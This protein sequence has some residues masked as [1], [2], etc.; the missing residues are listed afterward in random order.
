MLE[1]HGGR[2]AD[3]GGVEG[4][5]LLG[6]ECQQELAAAVFLGRGHRAVNLQG[7]RAWALGVAEDVQLG[8]IEA[9]EEVVRLAEVLV[10]IDNLDKKNMTLSY[11]E[12]EPDFGL[13]HFVAKFKRK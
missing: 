7:C 2:A 8:D 12:F 5:R 10:H 6:G 3:V 9:A 11:D 4:V 1:Q 13:R